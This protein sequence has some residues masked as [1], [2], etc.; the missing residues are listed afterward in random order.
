MLIIA[1]IK[2]KETSVHKWEEESFKKTLKPTY[3]SKRQRTFFNA[4][5]NRESIEKTYVL[6]K[7]LKKRNT[8]IPL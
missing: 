8:E 6:E 1:Q 2:T 3:F 7:K 5:P 4:L